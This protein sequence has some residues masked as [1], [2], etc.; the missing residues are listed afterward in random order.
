MI[1]VMHPRTEKLNLVL[2]PGER[3]K[4]T[5]NPSSPFMH[6]GQPYLLARIEN[7]D[8]E[9]SKVGLF[10]LSNMELASEAYIP[11]MQD[12]NFLGVFEDDD[13][14]WNLFGGVKIEL[15]AEGKVTSYHDEVYKIPK[16]QGHPLLHAQGQEEV[17]IEPFL[18]A[19]K[20]WKDTRFVQLRNGRIGAF[21]RPQGEF[22]GNGKIGYFES[23]SLATLQ[24]DLS[25]YAEAADESTFI[26]GIFADDEWGGP[27]Q[28][29]LDSRDENTIHV[30]GHRSRWIDQPGGAKIREYKAIYFAFN[31][32][33]KSL[34]G[35]VREIAEAADFE[36]VT[37]KNPELR[38][39]VFPS[40]V[41]AI[42]EKPGH[43]WLY[44]GVD[45]AEIWRREVA[46]PLTLDA[47][48]T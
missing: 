14:R 45:D 8:S 21:V 23:E 11:K 5:Y 10:S 3:D 19:P 47:S 37:P 43:Y 13:Q 42:E 15:D 32:A 29:I 4:T 40:G 35:E 9:D 2:V 30:I 34:V 46:L 16:T 1:E 24:A 17:E 28:L 36:G 41:V 39:I 48:Q 31:R 33:T 12:P 20:G 22:G 27:N 18:V 26:E 44:C 6:Q 7:R 25:A 38:N